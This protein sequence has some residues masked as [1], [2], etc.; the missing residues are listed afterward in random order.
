M[1]QL[2]KRKKEA[3]T[4]VIDRIWMSE[5]FKL[6]AFAGEWEKNKELVFITWFDETLERIESLVP[7]EARTSLLTAREA[8]VTHIAGK[9]VIMAE[10]YPVLQKEMDLFTKLGLKEVIVWSA[11]DEPL[12]HRFGGGKIIQLMKQLGMKE[13]DPI[14]HGMITK[15]IRNAQEKIASKVT[16]EQAA[17]SQKDWI[18]KNLPPD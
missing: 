1:F 11:L 18:E 5:S 3:Q 12:F 8:A 2:F 16:I 15:S 13:E 4:K 9:K 7:A 14:E 10:H 6:K 17:R